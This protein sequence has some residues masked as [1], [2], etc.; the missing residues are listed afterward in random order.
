MRIVL[1]HKTTGLYLQDMGSWTMD[2]SEA[3]EF[4]SST[5]AMEFCH[6]NGI[7]SLQIVLK[8]DQEKCD[9][10][11]QQISTGGAVEGP[12]MNA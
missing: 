3:L 5:A 11:M 2:S 10:V 9:I 6:R 1:Q 4:V 12:R 8:F 7:D